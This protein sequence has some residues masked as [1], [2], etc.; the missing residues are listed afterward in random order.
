MH[1][2]QIFYCKIGK[3]IFSF[4]INWS[5]FSYISTRN[6]KQFCLFSSDHLLP[7]CS[8]NTYFIVL[9]NLSLK[10]VHAILNNRTQAQELGGPGGA[11]PPPMFRLGGGGQHIVASLLKCPIS[12]FTKNEIDTPL[13]SS[14]FTLSFKV[15]TLY[16]DVTETDLASIKMSYLHIFKLR[17]VLN[18]S[19][20]QE[21][22]HYQSEN[23]LKIENGP[24]C[25]LYLVT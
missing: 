21:I 10:I 16:A 17:L 15:F 11:A 19:Y 20:V 14:R 13:N 9:M 8:L 1:F 18:L 3:Y 7:P 12:I 24:I 5:S 2:I 6:R 22:E 4:Y 23:Y 25:E